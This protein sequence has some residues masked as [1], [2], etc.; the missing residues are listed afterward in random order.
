MLLVAFLLR[1]WRLGAQSMWWD[2]M[3]TVFRAASTR[4]VMWADILRAR[5]QVPLYYLLM[6]PWVALGRGAFWVRYTSVWWGV[7]TVAL[8]CRLGVQLASRRVGVTAAALLAI[9]PLHV[10]YSQE[11]RAYTLLGALAVCSYLA[12]LRVMRHPR[13]KWGWLCYAVALLAA[14]YTHYFGAFLLLAQAIPLLLHWRHRRGLLLRWLGVAGLVGL[15]FLPWLIV[16]L[17]TGGF[18]Q[19]PVDWIAEAHWYE[20][21]LTLWAFGLGGTANPAHWWNWLAFAVLLLSFAWGWRWLQFQ[22][23]VRQVVQ[24]VA[25]WLAVP[26]LLMW[27][28]S[29]DLPGVPQRRSIYMDRYVTWLLPVFAL[30][31]AW[32]WHHWRRRHWSGWAVAG[33][34]LACLA[35]A[36]GTLYTDPSYAREDWRAGV[37]SLN[38]LAGRD[39]VLIRRPVQRLPLWYYPPAEELTV[40]EAPDGLPQGDLV[41]WLGLESPATEMWVI[42]SLD[43]TDPHGFPAG[44][45]R[46]LAEGATFDPLKEWLDARYRVDERLRFPGIVLTCYRHAGRSSDG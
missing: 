3:V 13:D 8:V 14:L 23:S 31:V 45:N 27:V 35:F 20:P 4:S 38:S 11:A 46:K 26:L 16:V 2:E 9:L 5:N 10:W 36:L 17:G 22:V 29:V 25:C 33:V 1:I 19:A 37:E 24:M 43:N 15:V 41:A 28:L 32:G 30:L 40:V 44:R 18:R 6:R 12:L 21:L 39:A 42:T 7:L 34:C